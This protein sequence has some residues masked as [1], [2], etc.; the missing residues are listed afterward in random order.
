MYWYIEGDR[1]LSGTAQTVIQD[2]GNEVLVSAASYWEI[3]IKVSLG[4]WTLNRPFEEFV[5]LGLNRYGFRLLPI[6]PRHAAR[7]ATLPFL[8]DHKDPFDRMLV[9]QA[10]VEGI[11]IASGDAQLDDYGVTRIW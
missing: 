1:Q 8:R 2:A 9:A 10:L 5:D 7:V 6:Q 11:G 3:A 4:K